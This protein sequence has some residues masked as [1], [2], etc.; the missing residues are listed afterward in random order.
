MGFA[1]VSIAERGTKGTIDESSR[2]CGPL[3]GAALAAEERT[4]DLAHGIHPLFDIHREGKKSAPGRRLRVA[5]A[6]ASTSVSPTLTTT[7]P[8]ACKANL[9]VL[10]RNSAAPTALRDECWD[11]F[12]LSVVEGAHARQLPVVNPR[13]RRGMATSN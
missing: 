2:Q 8:S 12:S 5:T 13:Q 9:P 11:M 6:V 10:N 4:G 7:A 1:E 3:G